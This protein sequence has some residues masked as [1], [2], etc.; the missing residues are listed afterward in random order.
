MHDNSFG[1]KDFGRAGGLRASPKD[2]SDGSVS[3]VFVG[4]ARL[5][6]GECCLHRN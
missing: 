1:I 2:E 6:V 5:C 3:S 4:M